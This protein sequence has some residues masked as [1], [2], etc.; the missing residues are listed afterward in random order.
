[1]AKKTYVKL[2]NT[3]LRELNITEI[4]DTTAATGQ[5]AMVANYFND[6]QHAVYTEEDWYSSYKE[7]IFQTSKD[8]YITIVANGSL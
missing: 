3:V 7:R 1:M 8:A 5:A 4:T 6:A 2:V